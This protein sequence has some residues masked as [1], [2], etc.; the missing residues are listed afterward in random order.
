MTE[1]TPE[2]LEK[3]AF[4]R[5]LLSPEEPRAFG[6]NWAAKSKKVTIASIQES[7]DYLISINISKHKIAVYSALLAFDADKL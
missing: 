7:Y 6:L 1:Y 4:I 3:I 5:E 2:Q